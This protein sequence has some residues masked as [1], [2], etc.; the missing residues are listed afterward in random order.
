MCDG[1]HI[2]I[3]RFVCC[4]VGGKAGKK[5]NYL[6]SNYTNTTR[7]ELVLTMLDSM[8]HHCTEVPRAR[9]EGVVRMRQQHS[10]SGVG[11]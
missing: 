8:F 3:G 4:Q 2:Y 5:S 6:H 1:R 7:A 9:Q 11:L 10:G